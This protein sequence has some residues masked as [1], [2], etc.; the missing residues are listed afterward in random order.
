MFAGGLRAIAHFAI[1][2]N[3]VRGKAIVAENISESGF[4]FG[5]IE[6]HS[7]RET[8]IMK[9]GVKSAVKLLRYIFA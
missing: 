6:A 7:R 9:N 1:A 5:M 4:S 3:G 2:L 8:L